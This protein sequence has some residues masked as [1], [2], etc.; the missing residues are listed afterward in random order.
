MARVAEAAFR[1]DLADAHAS[2]LEELRGA[3]ETEK[4]EIS[5][6]TH[7]G[8]LFHDGAQVI[9]MQEEGFADLG[10]RDAPQTVAVKVIEDPLAQRSR[11]AAR[12]ETEPSDASGEKRD[13][14]SSGDASAE[15]DTIGILAVYFFDKLAEISRV[16]NKKRTVELGRVGNQNAFRQIALSE[17]LRRDGSD[18]SGAGVPGRG[19]IEV[20]RQKN[21][22]S[23]RHSDTVED[24]GG[25]ID[26]IAG[27]KI[28]DSVASRK[29]RAAGGEKKDPTVERDPARKPGGRR[30]RE[31]PREPHERFKRAEIRFIIR[32]FKDRTKKQ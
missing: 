6:Q 13:K 17:I 4:D 20:E 11:N 9:G 5:V 23:G 31:R 15:D 22:S 10:V 3:V 2:R 1:G 16:G 30:H 25:D 12:A 21:S 18:G 28:E 27:A 29:A 26:K 7:P 19:K 14:I 24:A 32:H 8:A